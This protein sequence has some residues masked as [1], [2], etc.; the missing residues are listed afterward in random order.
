LFENGA[1]LKE[2]GEMAFKQPDDKARQPAAPGAAPPTAKPA[3]APGKPAAAEKAGKTAVRLKPATE[4]LMSLDAYRGL[5]MLLMASGGLA[6]GR[7]VHNDPDFVHKFEG[8]WFGKAWALFWQTASSQLEHV[9]WTGCTAWDLIQPSFMFMVGVAMPYS[10]ASRTAR[11]DSWGKQLLHA[12]IRSLILVALGIFLRSTHSPMTNFTFE[13]VLTQI[14]LGY[15]F[16]FLLLSAPFI[17]QLVALAVILGG[18]WFFFFHHPLPPPQGD[19]VT[20]YMT[21]VRGM[22]PEEW[23]QFGGPS[24]N[25]TKTPDAP[26]EAG[27]KPNA[28]SRLGGLAAHWNKHT[29]AAAE[30]DRK[31]LNFFPRPGES[32]EGKKFWINGG[33]YQTLNFIPSMATMLLGVMAG[34]LLRAPRTPRRKLEILIGAGVLCFVVS[35][36]IDTTI[37]PFQS[38]KLHYSF[39]PIVKRIWT[40]SW[41][42]FSA[43]WAFW[44]LAL[45]YWIVDMRG[46]RWFGFPFAIV[47]MNSIA[48]YCMADLIEPWLSSMLKIQLAAFDAAAHTSLVARLY[49]GTAVAAVWRECAVLFLIWLICL[50]LYRRRLFIRI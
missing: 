35:M 5:T 37:W 27:A 16:V 26:A 8:K 1:P 21:E 3:P 23:H 40:P 29:N 45:W 22:N 13:D 33:G 42:V 9:A 14:G 7:L 25:P 24:A 34:Q 44:F 30:F 46:H 17:A 4:R 10:Y 31:F 15:I 19:L 28:S 47:G 2:S 6:I 38:E 49:A 32:W 50:W 36:A 11:G 20:R 43:G 48:V 41:A 18:Y 39:A 12:A